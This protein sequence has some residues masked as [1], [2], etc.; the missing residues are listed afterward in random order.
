MN[1]SEFMSVIVD[2]LHLDEE[3]IIIIFNLVEIDGREIIDNILNQ[4]DNET[5]EEFLNGVIIYKRGKKEVNPK[6]KQKAP[7]PIKIR[8]N[9]NNVVFKKLKIAFE[10]S[11]EDLVKMFEDAGMT[12][13]K[14][15]LTTYFRKEGHKHYRILEDGTL[16]VFLEG[17]SKLR[18]WHENC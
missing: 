5:F 18:N 2:A 12:M 17:V 16:R 11:N 7:L 8:K 9:I 6:A 1:N 15:E 3:Q 4:C 10:F 14:N 13:T